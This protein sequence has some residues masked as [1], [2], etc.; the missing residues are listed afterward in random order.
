M[1][2]GRQVVEQQEV[3]AGGIEHIEIEVGCD[4][5]G[6]GF[7]K[8][9]PH[10]LAAGTQRFRAEMGQPVLANEPSLVRCGLGQPDIEDLAGFQRQGIPVVGLE[11]SCVS[12]FR[13][14]ML[15]LF[16][17]DEDTQRLASQTKPSGNC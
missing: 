7:P 9:C 8:P 10:G 14:E 2:F 16:P 3:V 13:D 6:V 5:L 12:V 17:H 11:P 4:P 15:N 1:R